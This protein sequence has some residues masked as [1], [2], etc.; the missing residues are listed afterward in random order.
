MKLLEVQ[1][2]SD[3]TDMA[4]QLHISGLLPEIAA[5]LLR[6]TDGGRGMAYL[7]CCY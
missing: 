2:C 4:I 5:F 3:Q 6:M 1:E 7:Y